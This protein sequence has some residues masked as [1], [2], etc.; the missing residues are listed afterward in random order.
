MIALVREPR[1][2]K[3]EPRIT[4]LDVSRITEA[5]KEGVDALTWN[6]SAVLQQPT[7]S[8]ST[9]YLI[10]KIASQAVQLDKVHK[11]TAMCNQ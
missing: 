3:W 8:S 5:G 6:V 10:M 4:S 11:A 1:S 2:V 7:G 9:R